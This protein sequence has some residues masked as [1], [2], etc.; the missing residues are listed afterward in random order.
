MRGIGNASVI[1]PSAS[2]PLSVLIRNYTRIMINETIGNKNYIG[3]FC[4]VA[5]SC[6]MDAYLKIKVRVLVRLNAVIKQIL[7]LEVYIML[8]MRVLRIKIMNYFEIWTGNQAK[9]YNIK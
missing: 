3:K 6:F 2:L 9:F 8:L 1:M 4:F 5:A 7:T